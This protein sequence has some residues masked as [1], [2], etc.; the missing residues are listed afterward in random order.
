MNKWVVLL[1]MA[2][3]NSFNTITD[4]EYRKKLYIY[5]IMQWLNNTNF[6]IVVI[7]SS[8]YNFPEIENERLHKIS[9]KLTEK[10]SS[11]SQYE[12]NSILY[13]LDIIKNTQYYIITMCILW[14]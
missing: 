2:I 8:G 13:A 4:T 10:L 9:F 6:I 12:A 14:S 5:Q 1:T 3:S 11:T 7:E